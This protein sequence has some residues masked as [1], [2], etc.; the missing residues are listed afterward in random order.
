MIEAFIKK[1]PSKTKFCKDVGISPQYLVQIE[2]GTRP[3]PPKVCIVLENKF[4]AD[5]HILRPDIFGVATVDDA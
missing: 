4:G 2:N 1:Y 5:K 3:I